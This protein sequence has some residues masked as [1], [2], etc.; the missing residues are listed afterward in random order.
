M[1][2][3][4]FW[5]VWFFSS[6]ASTLSITHISNSVP[7]FLLQMLISHVS[8]GGPVQGCTNRCSLAAGLRG[9]GERMRKWGGNREKMRKWREIDSLHFLILSL[10]P[11]SLCISYIQMRHIF[12]QNVKYGTFVAN[13][14]KI[15][16]Y[17]LWGN[18][19]GSNLLQGSSAICAGLSH[20]S[21]T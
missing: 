12:L 14:T 8:I 3:D 2:L 11:P 19:S 10:F 6:G 17:A 1:Y 7:F 15:S 16:T 18:N 5:Y 9:N 4:I 20:S 21:S 13:V